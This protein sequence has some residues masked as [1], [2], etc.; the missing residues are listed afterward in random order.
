MS[1]R[2]ESHTYSGQCPSL[3]IRR[4]PHVDEPSRSDQ[5]TDALIR[6]GLIRTDGDA[7][8]PDPSLLAGLHEGGLEPDESERWMTHLAECRRCQATL[9]ALARADVEAPTA[10]APA[11]SWWSYVQR[12]LRW[13]VLVPL[14]AGAVIV[15]AVWVVDPG[16]TVG[17]RRST[18][19]A[20]PMPL[21]KQRRSPRASQSA[22]RPAS[23]PVPPP[24]G[25]SARTP[26]GSPK[27]K[28][29][30]W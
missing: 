8:C 17:P 2:S 18:P 6:G 15:L 13:P 23:G 9:A 28:T 11:H 5:I 1:Q 22:S 27:T 10:H 25:R 30:A 3:G 12:G 4:E 24:I 29:L 14:A 21:R 20:A 26:P 7:T 16:S 19:S